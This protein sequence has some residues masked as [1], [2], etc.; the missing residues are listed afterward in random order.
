VSGFCEELGTANQNGVNFLLTDLDLALTFMDI[1]EVSRHE[2][3]VR[4][5]H[6]SARKAY[7]TVVRLLEKLMP[8]VEQRQVIDAN[9]AVLKAR[10]QA[11]GQQF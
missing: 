11:V 6:N 2:E 3:T 4:R 8:D 7:D 1:A 9:L 10:L 5:N